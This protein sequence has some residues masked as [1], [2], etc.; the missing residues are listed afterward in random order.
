MGRFAA[1]NPALVERL[2]LYAP[3]W[4][5]PASA[6]APPTAPESPLG[7]YRTVTV[8]AARRG[9]GAG[10]PE[11]RRE[12]LVP[13][14]WF[15]HWSGVT[16]ATDAE[17][18]RRNPPVL[19]LPNGPGADIREYW[20]AGRP[21]YDAAKIVAPSLIVVGEWDQVT[22]PG[23]AMG[24]FSQLTNAAGKRLV[25]LGGGTHTM[26][27]ERNRAALFQAVQVFLEESF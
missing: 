5:R 20:M 14:G 23:M 9:I 25:V 11:D 6:A 21:W 18:M 19:R 7:A 16:W 4:V 3:F 26:W 22:P 8:D 27:M 2:A 10:A 15:E 13:P 24:L 1:E 12:G 17:G